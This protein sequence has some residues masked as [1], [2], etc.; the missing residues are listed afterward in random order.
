MTGSP[1]SAAPHRS[2]VSIRGAAAPPAPGPHTPP[3][4]AP[5]SYGSPSS[6]RAEDD[7]IVVEVGSRFVRV[8]FAGDN[9]PR[10]RL[11]MPP[12]QQRRVGDY[13]RWASGF[14]DDWTMRAAGADWGEDY[15]LWRYD[16]RSV[17][18][19]LVEDKLERLLR[20][21]F[22]KWVLPILGSG[23]SRGD[24]SR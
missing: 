19:G 17:D 3:R 4:N 11:Q 23:W 15:E 6:L 18:L 20:E 10:V 8:G 12:E 22:S 1:G 5:P 24:G 2:V 21:A 9:A 16:L 13:R 14:E 7:V